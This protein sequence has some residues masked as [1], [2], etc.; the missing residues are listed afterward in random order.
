MASAWTR[1]EVEI[2]VADFSRR[3]LNW[4]TEMS[5]RQNKRSTTW[6]ELIERFAAFVAMPC[7]RASGPD[8]SRPTKAAI[9][10]TLERQLNRAKD[11]LPVRPGEVTS[12]HMAAVLKRRNLVPRGAGRRPSQSTFWHGLWRAIVLDRDEYRCAFCRRSAFDGL[13]LPREGKLALRLELDH[14]VPRA[15][16][17]DDYSLGNIRAVCRT[18]NTARGRLKDEHFRAELRSIA[19]SVLQA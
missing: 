18:C 15:A 4:R 5:R 10:R 16:R 19:K 8:R 3:H 1:D 6:G 12:R 9:V 14:V 2:I 7:L 11:C 17:G 13:E